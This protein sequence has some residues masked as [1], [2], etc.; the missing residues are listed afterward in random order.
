MRQLSIVC[1]LFAIA[2]LAFI[3]YVLTAESFTQQI[4]TGPANYKDLSPPYN[5]HWR[6]VG[7]ATSLSNQ[8]NDDLFVLEELNSPNSPVYRYRVTYTYSSLPA[9]F[10]LN[11]SHKATPNEV[12][13]AIAPSN[14]TKLVSP[15]NL[16]FLRQSPPSFRLNLDPELSLPPDVPPPIDLN[17]K[18]INA[19]WTYVGLAAPDWNNFTEN[20]FKLYEKTFENN[21]YLYKVTS[22]FNDMPD[23]WYLN[24]NSQKIMDCGIYESQTRMRSNNFF[25]FKVSLQKENYS[26]PLTPNP[27]ASS[28]WVRIGLARLHNASNRPSSYD[29][30]LEQ[31]GPFLRIWN[32]EAR[33]ISSHTNSGF[34]YDTSPMYI[35]LQGF[36]PPKDREIRRAYWNPL[37]W[38]SPGYYHLHLK[39]KN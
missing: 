31:L 9:T 18:N 13:S 24:T 19:D 28:S 36:D 17:N 38:Q 20:L 4:S 2:L 33:R 12:R 7:T 23:T 3:L 32:P 35:Y 39:Q 1:G 30:I 22:I 15:L 21:T 8:F 27:S 25:R 11:G 29:Y 26:H 16:N 14:S 5:P 10:Y 37:N 34:T 6:K